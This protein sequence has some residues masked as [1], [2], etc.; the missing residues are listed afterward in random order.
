MQALAKAGRVFEAVAAIPEVA[1]LVLYTDDED[2]ALD[3]ARAMANHQNLY[4]VIV[5]DECLDA[6]AFQLAKILQ[7]VDDRVRL[8]TSASSLRSSSSS[9]THLANAALLRSGAWG[10]QRGPCLSSL[11]Q[12]RSEAAV[13][14]ARFLATSRQRS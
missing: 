6:T 1:P 9:L 7:G 2:K 11:G 5:A 14:D 12:A 10:A 3:L 13:K 4:A 8:V